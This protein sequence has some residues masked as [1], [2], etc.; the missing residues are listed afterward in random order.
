MPHIY[1][2]GENRFYLP[3]TLIKEFELEICDE[4]GNVSTEIYENHFRFSTVK[5]N[6]TVKSIR[7]IP[8]STHGCDHFQMFCV[9]P[10]I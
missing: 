10:I 7:F 3:E 1:P 9:E 2:L 4:S 5:I 6:K 8:K